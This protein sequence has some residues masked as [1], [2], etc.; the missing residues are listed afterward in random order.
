MKEHSTYLFSL[1]YRL[2]GSYE[3]A[4]DLLQETFIKAWRKWDHLRNKENPVPWLRK[5]CINVF[6]DKRR[7]PKTKTIVREISFPD[8]FPNMEFEIVSKTPSPEDEVLA[9]EEVRLVHSQCFTIISSTLTLYQ[10]IVLILND[11]YQVGIEETAVLAGKS[12]SATKS[13]L[14]RSREKMIENFGP[15]C[16]VVDSENNCECKSWIGFAHDIQK[17]REHLNHILS[18]QIKS[19]TKI[20][21]TKKRIIRLFNN[22][23]LHPPPPLWIDEVIKKIK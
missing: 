16:S 12:Y 21:E 19:K 15:H 5:I 3:E 4:Q 14:H 2:T 9:D 17:R 8:V 6:I 18:T 22:L 13:L 7:K 20:G 23:P 1:L 10:R 11:I